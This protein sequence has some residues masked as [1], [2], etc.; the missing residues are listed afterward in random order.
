MPVL[1]TTAR[2]EYYCELGKSLPPTPARNRENHERRM[3]TAIEAFNALNPA[4]AYEGR[5]AVQVVLCGAHAADNLREAGL[6]QDDFAKM[7]RCRAQAASMMREARA[8]KRMLA[9]EQKLRLAVAAVVCSAPV[10]PAAAESA[11]T[12]PAEPQATPPLPTRA[13][14]TPP[15]AAPGPQQPV[16]PRR[17]A[18]DDA[19]AAI[20]NHRGAA[21]NTKAALLA[22]AFPTHPAVLDALLRGAGA[23]PNPADKAGRSP[24]GKAA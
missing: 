12:R 5:L 8:A 15:H 19:A 22:S 6:R 9:Q 10:Q 24:L 20:R 16:P 4:D 14:V 18:T 17:P 21:P 2:H 3:T 23:G 11:S 7:T 1:S 13:A